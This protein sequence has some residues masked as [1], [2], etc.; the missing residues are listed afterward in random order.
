MRTHRLIP[1]NGP[2]F[3]TQVH[4]GDPFEMS[5]GVPLYRAPTGG[6]GS[7]PN[8]LGAS[9][10]GWDP[11][12]T[13]VGVDAGYSPE[14]N[15]LRAP[16]VAVGNVPNKPG[17][18]RGAPELA[19]EYADVGQD[20][21]ALQQ[22]IE[23]LLE[24]GTKV[25]WVVRLT[26]ARRVEIHRPGEPVSVALPGEQ[27]R[28]P[29]VLQNPVPVEALY[30]RDAAERAT[31]TNLLQ[32]RGYADLDAVLRKGREEG[33]EEGA[34]RHARMAL[35]HMLARRKL[36]VPAEVAA[37]IDACTDLRQLEEWSD[38]TMDG[39][40]VPQIFGDDTLP[41]PGHPPMSSP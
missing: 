8:A 41:P 31:F 33:R 26:G 11:A 6:S 16:D 3:A 2:F 35:H 25:L 27:L 19:V 18:I 15:M 34:L 13:E 14:P 22:K 7:G 20:E 38:R 12:V 28:A 5:H 37:R 30:D 17:W 32:R 1:E 23:D 39:A 10:L 29:G 4:S 9:V 21:T 36:T 40:E 24:A